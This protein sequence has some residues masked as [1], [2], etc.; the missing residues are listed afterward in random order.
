MQSS[1]ER[2]AEARALVGKRIEIPVHYDL[3]MR[4]AR[5][6]KVTR[7][8]KDGAWVWVRMEHPQVKCA[9]KV[10]STDFRY[11]KIM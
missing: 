4:G 8:G 3:W 7:V 2:L 9:K 1:D 6:G 5:F 11:I 10:W